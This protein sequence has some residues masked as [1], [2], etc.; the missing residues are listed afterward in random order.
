[1]EDTTVDED[2]VA[3][4]DMIVEEDVGLISHADESLSALIL[5]QLP[6]WSVQL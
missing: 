6:L 4:G 5:C 2:L 3:G 1:M